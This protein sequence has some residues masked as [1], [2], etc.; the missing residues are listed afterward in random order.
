MLIAQFH[1]RK[2]DIF[3]FLGNGVH[4]G[5]K[6]SDADTIQTIINFGFCFVFDITI[7]IFS[8]QLSGP[9]P[10]CFDSL[11]SNLFLA[12]LNHWWLYSKANDILMTSF[13]NLEIDLQT[14]KKRMAK[15][16]A[17]LTKPNGKYL[18]K[19]HQLKV[20]FGWFN[21]FLSLSTLVE[22]L[23]VFVCVCCFIHLNFQWLPVTNRNVWPPYLRLSVFF[24]QFYFSFLFFL[25]FCVDFVSVFYVSCVR[26]FVR[27]VVF[28]LSR[29]FV[30]IILVSVKIRVHVHIVFVFLLSSSKI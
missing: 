2:R 4:F 10:F 11:H 3:I 22:L 16:K 20:N 21:F 18:R 1:N 25:S 14:I 8:C 26:S 17:L 29:V 13:Y 23:N 7:M 28:F 6:N 5:A 24:F 27:L 15:P 19:I 12:Q 30:F 9:F